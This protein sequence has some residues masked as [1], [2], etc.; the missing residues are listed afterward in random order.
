MNVV[1]KVLIGGILIP[2][3]CVLAVHQLRFI[4]EVSQRPSH[5]FVSYYVASHLLSKGTDVSQYY[6]DTWYRAQ[7]RLITPGIEDIYRPHTP[8]MGF[9]LLP[10]AHLNHAS[11]RTIWILFNLLSVVSAVVWIRRAERFNMIWT[12]IAFMITLLYQPLYVNFE[13]GQIYGLLFAVLTLIWYGYRHKYDRFVGILLGI[14][15]ILKTAGLLLLPFFALQRRWKTLLW[16]MSTICMIGLLSL[17]IVGIPSWLAFLE[18]LPEYSQRPAFAVTA[19]QGIPG[20]FKHHFFYHPTWNPSPLVDLPALGSLLSLSLI[21]VML[22]FTLWKGNRSKDHKL[23]F[24]ALLGLGVIISPVS[25]DYHYAILLLPILLLLADIQ[26]MTLWQKGGLIISIILL[27]VDYPYQK[28]PYD[29]TFLSL[30][31]YP[32]LIGGVILWG[33]IMSL[34]SVNKSPNQA[35]S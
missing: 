12:T 35:V 8:T 26:T 21:L 6:D 3:V 34:M 31:A 30:M 13:Y 29:E 1:R 16:T 28:P 9:I 4:Q 27:A 19:Y 24:C 20:F 11:A 14:I 2:L 22:V 23:L 18:V 15:L 32:K 5:G 7:T 10:L 33:L 17:P 25:L